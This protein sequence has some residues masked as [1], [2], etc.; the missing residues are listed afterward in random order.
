V[1]WNDAVADGESLFEICDNDSGG[2][3]EVFTVICDEEEKLR[4]ELEIED[5]FD[6]V[7]FIYN[8]V[9]HP[10]VQHHAKAILDPVADL[11][12]HGVLVGTWRGIVGL[13]DSDFA[14]LGFRKVVDTELIYRQSAFESD[15]GRKFPRG[16]DVDVPGR[17][18]MEE[19]VEERWKSRD[20]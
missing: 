8:V 19:W 12:G 18:D 11:F 9:L 17:P 6:Y 3:C 7:V 2:L 4:P 20:G 1:L 14:E 16:Q 5:A 13:S 10:D 15:F